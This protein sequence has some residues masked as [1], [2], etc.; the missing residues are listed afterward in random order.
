VSGGKNCG[1]A[2]GTYDR[3]IPKEGAGVKKQP[4]S[5]EALEFANVLAVEIF[6]KHCVEDYYVT[7]IAS[8][9]E[10]WLDGRHLVRKG[11]AR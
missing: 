6:G 3:P 1:G 2:G 10:K 5:P 9:F 11:S 7:L 4:P 8:V